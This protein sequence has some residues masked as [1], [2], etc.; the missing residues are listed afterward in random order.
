MWRGGGC[1]LILWRRWGE[2]RRRI[3]V[4]L[5]KLGSGLIDRGKLSF[6]ERVYG[7]TTKIDPRWNV[8]FYNLGLHYK[9]TGRWDKSL[10]YNQCAL[11]LE[12]ADRAACW[13]LGIAATALKNWTEARRA[14]REYGIQLENGDGEV[15]MPMETAC[16]R[17]NPKGNGEVVWGL[18]IDPA[19]IVIL[20]VPLPESGHRFHDIVLNDGASEGTRIDQRGKEVPVIDDL[21]IWEVSAYSTY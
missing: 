7:W 16:V 4:T 5:N 2:M 8:P 18:R 6:G 20:S 10:F 21:S 17:L 3:A 1:L 12:P 19:R 9:N 13:N 11:K 15:R 14:W